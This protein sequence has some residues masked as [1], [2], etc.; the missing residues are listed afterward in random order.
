MEK[1]KTEKIFLI[2]AFLG[3][4]L[5]STG[6]SYAA[7]N[8]LR[9][10]SDKK[11]EQAVLPE[12]E[13]QLIDA[14][15]PKTEECPLNGKMYTEAE[16]E[17]WSKRRPL[18][19]MV[20]NHQEARPQSGISR[21]DVVYEAVAEGGITRFMLLFY[22]GV[23]A[24]DT[25][26]GPVRSARTYFLDWAS[27]YSEYPLYAHVGGA[28]CDP[29]TG[30]GCLNGAKADALGQIADYGWEGGSDLNQFSI[31]YPT[32]WR[33][34]ERIGHTVATEHTMY[35]TTEKLWKVAEQRGY[36]NQGPEE[37]NWN[38]S[39]VSWTF[40]DGETGEKEVEKIAFNFWEDY[41]DYSVEWQYDGENNNYKRV[42]GGEPHK[43]LNNDEQLTAHNIVIQF[44]KES[45]ANDGYPGNVHLLYGTIG[46]GDAMIFQNGKAIEGQWSKASR[47]AR[48]EFTDETGAEIEF[49]RGR[50]WIE[51]VPIGTEVDY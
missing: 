14:T 1:K 45:S 46:Q 13:G 24:V 42:N 16:K 10:G 17:A 43:D 3:I 21:T 18:A 29:E 36:T 27:E 22:C 7:F 40:Q 6:I 49:V 5:L 4:Y 50:I 47:T 31:G 33:D 41:G 25:T 19:V 30:D 34:Y 12:E 20:E 44:M 23:Q 9:K 32:F 28:H 8:F 2:L 26:I 15:G 39:F 38:D 35:S 51:G 37:E 11:Q 48:T